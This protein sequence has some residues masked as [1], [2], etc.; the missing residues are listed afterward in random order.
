M[1]DRSPAE[2]ET[3][4]GQDALHSVWGFQTLWLINPSLF[5]RNRAIRPSIG[6]TIATRYQDSTV[7]E[8]CGCGKEMR[9]GYAASTRESACRT[10]I[11][12]NLGSTTCDQHV[13]VPKTRRRGGQLKSRQ[14][15]VGDSS[16]PVRMRIEN[17]GSA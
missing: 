5:G 13:T 7:I 4:R 2:C 9:F 10:V 14:F 17:F 15:H 12:L 1:R 3:R 11:N 6:Q 8:E 16:K